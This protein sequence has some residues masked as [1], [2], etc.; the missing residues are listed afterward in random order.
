[1]RMRQAAMG[2]NLRILGFFRRL[3][4]TGR[5]RHNTRMLHKTGQ[6]L[7]KDGPANEE[8]EQEQA[9]LADQNHGASI[10]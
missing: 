6:G 5:T 3:M 1:M 7:P 10:R 4:I 9:M 2:G 8:T